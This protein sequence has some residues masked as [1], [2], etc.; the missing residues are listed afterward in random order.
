M[1][2]FYWELGK[3]IK[4]KIANLPQLVEKLQSDLFSVPWGHHRYIIATNARTILTKSYS[5]FVKH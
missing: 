1:L 5:M 3:D 4:E 2:S